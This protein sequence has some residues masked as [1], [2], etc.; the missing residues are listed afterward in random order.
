VNDGSN[1]SDARPGKADFGEVGLLRRKAFFLGLAVAMLLGSAFAAEAPIVVGEGGVVLKDGEPWRGIGINYFSA[2]GRTLK[3]GDDTSYREGFEVLRAHGIPFIRFMAGGFWPNEMRLY[4]DGREEYFRRL[5]GVVKAAEDAGLGL[6]PSLFWYSACVPDLVGEPRNAWGKPGSKTHAFM[7]RYVEDV[8]MRY[9]D[10]PAVWAWEFGNEYSLAADLPNAGQH[11]P[12]IHPKLGTPDKR[13]A[14]D[15]LT[16]DDIVAAVGE[17]AKT[18][19][20]FDPK[21]PITTGHSLPRPS[22]QHQRAELSWKHDTPEQFAANLLEVTPDPNNLV[23]VHVY[24]FEKKGRFGREGVAY[25][26]V[27]ELCMNTARGAGK[28]LFVGEFGAPDT[29]ED[30]GP[31]KARAE[32]KEILAAIV[33]T[34]VPLAALWNYDLPSQEHFINITPTNHRSYLLDELQKANAALAAAREAE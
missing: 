24:P 3:D 30:G 5:D 22:A 33:D 7:R 14:D 19:R 25:R 23:S 34:G 11:R 32:C 15:D 29:E 13:S 12:W 18:V 8:V 10:S 17:F 28:A 16:H 27:L 6:I 2:F 4:L 26:E 31:E 1:N 20:K 21:R 9:V